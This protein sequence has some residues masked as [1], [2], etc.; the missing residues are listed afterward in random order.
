[1]HT[2]IPE[3]WFGPSM[4]VSNN[5]SMQYIY[6]Y[7][8]HLPG[9]VCLGRGCP[10]TISYMTC[11]K[12]TTSPSAS[13]ASA[14]RDSAWRWFGKNNTCVCTWVCLFACMC[15]IWN[16]LAHVYMHAC[17]HSGAHVYYMSV[18]VYVCVCVYVCMY[19]YI[20]IYIYIRMYTRTVAMLTTCNI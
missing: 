13:A 2:H 11:P 14:R 12:H 18:S 7:T 16:L 9:N 4:Y 1:M 8:I 17:S 5:I 15:V 20:Y 6:I 19:V 3:A 10:V